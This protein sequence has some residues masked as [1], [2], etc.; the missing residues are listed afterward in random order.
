MKE[1]QDLTRKLLG[2]DRLIQFIPTPLKTNEVTDKNR[3][4]ETGNYVRGVTFGDMAQVSL[5][6]DNMTLQRHEAFHIAEEIGLIN[7]N[8]I[9]FLNTKNKEIIKLIKEAQR[10]E[11]PKV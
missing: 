2:T 7:V 8:D 11:H 1:L 3:L 5:A 4:D 6:Y 9:Q 10:L